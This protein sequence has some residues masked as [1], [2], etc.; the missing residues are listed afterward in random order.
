MIR[1]HVSAVNAQLQQLYW[2]RCCQ[3]DVLE[4][5]SYLLL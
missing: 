1:F 4:Q 2:G 3:A 5:L